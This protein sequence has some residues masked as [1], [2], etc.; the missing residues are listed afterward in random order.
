MH[1]APLCSARPDPSN[2]STVVAVVSKWAVPQCLND[3]F[4]DIGLVSGVVLVSGN[5]SSVSHA[6]QGALV[7]PQPP[8]N[9]SWKGMFGFS[10]KW[11]KMSFVLWLAR[12]A[13][14][15]AWHLEDDSVSTVGWPYLVK[16]YAADMQSD[17][18]ADFDWNPNHGL[19]HKK[20]GRPACSICTPRV[21]MA[22]WPFLRMSRRLA[23]HIET[24]V[25]AGG[26]GHHEIF[27]L[28]ACYRMR[29]GCTIRPMDLTH[30]ILPNQWT[31]SIRYVLPGS[32][33]LN[34]AP[35]NSTMGDNATQ[36][37][38]S[39]TNDNATQPRNS[40]MNSTFFHPIKCV[41]PERNLKG[42][43]TPIPKSHIKERHPV[44][45]VWRR[46]GVHYVSGV[47]G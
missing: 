40:T 10:S 18:I 42:V 1:D 26:R 9:Q 15:F 11:A 7:I 38:N 37:R 4:R 19:Y 43:A 46:D 39:T 36:P 32:I 28:A 5:A 41:P 17:V 45:A 21:G 27:T 14:A 22:M 24:E 3:R 16:M 8:V 33:L 13:H 6:P 47:R 23:R 29:T 44:P 31:H 34:N 25:L 30:Q 35:R 2:C 12:S 20:I